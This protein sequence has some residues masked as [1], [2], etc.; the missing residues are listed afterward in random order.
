MMSALFHFQHT[1]KTYF[2][3]ILILDKFFLKY[4]GGVKLTPLLEKTTLK[5]PRLIR[6]KERS[7]FPHPYIALNFHIF[8]PYCSHI[9]A[10]IFAGTYFGLIFRKIR[11]LIFEKKYTLFYKGRIYKKKPWN[12]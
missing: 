8:Q 12:R 4:E 10:L 2:K 9:S 6:V 11:K 3:V 1:L 7:G 5:K